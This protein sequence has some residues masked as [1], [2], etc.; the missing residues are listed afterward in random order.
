MNKGTENKK[1]GTYKY[2]A[3]TSVGAA[4]EEAVCSYISRMGYR[5]LERN[6]RIPGGEIDIIA[7]DKDTYVFIEV[8]TR[9][10]ADF[11][12]ACE[13]V[14]KRKQGH[15][16]NTALA[17]T[18]T[19]DVNMRFDV[20]EVYYEIYCGEFLVKEINYIENAFEGH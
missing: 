5:I 6:Y 13:Y 20:A 1:S 14:T 16:I 11:G 8:K 19:D 10:N 17:Y 3:K 12:Q 15:I 9:K 2:A 4:G 18:K 7:L